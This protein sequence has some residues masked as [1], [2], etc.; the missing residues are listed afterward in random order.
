M[1]GIAEL[2]AT[3]FFYYTRLELGVRVETGVG[4]DDG[5]WMGAGVDGGRWKVDGGR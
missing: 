3:Y 5:R 1:E 2:G 4:V